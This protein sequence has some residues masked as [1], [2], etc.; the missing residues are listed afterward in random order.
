MVKYVLVDLDGTIADSME[1]VTKSIQYALKKYNIIV[2]DR[3]QL[4]K[5]I[6]PPIIWSFTDAGIKPSDMD[7]AIAAYREKYNN[8]E[9]YDLTIYEG[10]PEALDKLRASGLKLILAT[11]KPI[12][13][14]GR[15]MDRFGVSKYFDEMCGSDSDSSRNTKQAVI[16]YILEKNNITDLSEVIMVGDTKYDVEGAKACNVDTIGVLWGFGSKESLLEAGAKYICETPEKL[17]DIVTA[18]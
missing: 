2:E 9:M 5:Y 15:I 1:G 14:A 12:S 13:F 18:I 17:C 4:R 7:D 8:E 6:G 16:E 3:N 11:S 10:V